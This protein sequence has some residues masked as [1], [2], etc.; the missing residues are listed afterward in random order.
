MNQG[1]QQQPQQQQYAQQTY[2]AAPPTTPTA[3]AAGAAKK[4]PMLLASAG[5]LVVF[6]LSNW[7]VGAFQITGDFGR[8]LRH[9]G[10]AMGTAGFGV[11]LI[12]GFERLTEKDKEHPTGV[13][14]GLVICMLLIA[15]VGLSAATNLK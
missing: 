3:P 14:L 2:Q 5:L 1:Y 10:I 9:T 7:L 12:M 13:G 11:L 6:V 8:F 15:I 4:S